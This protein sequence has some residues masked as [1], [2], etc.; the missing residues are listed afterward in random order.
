M[1]RFLMCGVLGPVLAFYLYPEARPRHLMPVAF[2]AAVLAAVMVMGASR[3][4][5]RRPVV[6]AATVAGTMLAGWGV[7]NAFV[8]PWR[9]PLAPTRVA[10]EEVNGK[11]PPGEPLYTTRTYPVTGEGYYNLQ[12]HLAHDIRAADLEQLKQAAP[13]LAVATPAERD[14]LGQD[15]LSIEVVGRLASRGGPPE[16]LVIRLG[17]R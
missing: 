15:G 16:L 1:R 8:V 13:C 9:A 14:Q 3:T 12:F 17:R 10:L 4:L 2:P 7:F 6:V 5:G 11:L